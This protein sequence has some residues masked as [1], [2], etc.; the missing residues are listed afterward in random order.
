MSKQTT[1]ARPYAKAVF[2]IAKDEADFKT[3]HLQLKLLA[4]VASYPEVKK[5]LKNKLL[6]SD[7]LADF[8]IEVCHETLTKRGINF[9]KVLSKAKRLM[10][11]PDIYSH[12]KIFEAQ[13][14][15]VMYVNILSAKPLNDIEQAKL[16]KALNK[17]FGLNIV[18]RNIVDARVIGGVVIRA[19]DKVIDSSV[20]GRLAALEEALKVVG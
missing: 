8:F 10:L 2:E 6:D 1:L 9:I 4:Q 15:K 20:R 18:A 14:E 5:L 16:T 7:D 13:A 19:G 12:Y 3:W 17:K 11:L